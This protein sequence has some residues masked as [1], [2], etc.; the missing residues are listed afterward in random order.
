[1]A[2]VVINKGDSHRRAIYA[3][4]LGDV[5]SV[6]SCEANGGLVTETSPDAGTIDGIFLEKYSCFS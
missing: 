4:L 2:G 6:W 1:M 3:H 5:P